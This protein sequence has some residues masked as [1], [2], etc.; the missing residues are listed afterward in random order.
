M[1]TVPFLA[2]ALLVGCTRSEPAETDAARSLRF[3]VIGDYGFPAQGALDV[4]A[5]IEGWDVDFV[6]TAGDNNYPDGTAETIDLNIGKPYHAFI[7]PYNGAHGE[8]ATENRFWPS[9]GNH[10]WNTGTLQPYL[11]FFELPGNERYY[12]I[13]KGSVEIFLL[14]S[15]GA[16]PDGR[17]ADSVQAQWLQGALAASDATYK[18]VVMHHPPYS[19]GDHGNTAEMQW[20]FADWGAD[21]VIAGHDHTYERLTVDGF[22]YLVNGLGGAF[23]YQFGEPI[24]GSEVRFTGAL[25][26]QRVEET[27]EG[28]RFE[29]VTTAGE[30]VDTWTLAP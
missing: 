6:V 12:A 10:D 27:A 25:G 18:L 20:P 8:G 16:E 7:H 9:P 2:A 23:F 1:R 22:P 29:F 13:R 21:V 24:A 26:A 4:A 15:D 3:A 28:L 14:D 11:D 17:T 5:M 30:T 19:S